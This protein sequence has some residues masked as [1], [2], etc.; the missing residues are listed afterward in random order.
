M[1]LFLQAVNTETTAANTIP[2][3]DGPAVMTIGRAEGNDF[4]LNHSSI[5]GEHA[6][7]EASGVNGVEL[8]DCNSSNG[9]FVNGV[10][11]GRKDLRPGDVVKFAYL[12]YRVVESEVP[13]AQESEA[14]PSLPEEHEVRERSETGGSDLLAEVESLRSQLT[15]SESGRSA[16]ETRLEEGRSEIQALR[17]SL[18]EQQSLLAREKLARQEEAAV[19]RSLESELEV[20]KGRNAE[21]DAG[22]REEHDAR[23]RSEA[24][25]RELQSEVESLRTR[26]ANSEE[27]TG[28]ANQQIEEAK[29]ENALLHARIDEV[30][31]MRGQVSEE[32]AAE[33]SLREQAESESA[34][35]LRE[36]QS[37]NEQLEKAREVRREREAEILERDRRIA[38]LEFEA[39][40]QGRT[41]AATE[42]RVR[43]LEG[44]CTQWQD[45][46]EALKQSLAETSSQLDGTQGHLATTETTLEDFQVRLRR[47]LDQ[48]RKDWAFWRIE[49]EPRGEGTP[50]T[51][52]A[53]FAEAESLRLAMRRELD[54]VEPI[55]EK[56]G[57]R[58]QVELEEQV[59]SLEKE[60][61]ELDTEAEEKR[62]EV[63]SLTDDVRGLREEVDVEVRRAQGLSRRGVQIEIP[64]RFEAMVIAKDRERQILLS[65]VN[66]LEFLERLTEGYRRSRKLREVVYE[67][68]ELAKRLIGILEENGVEEFTVEP[69]SELTLKQRKEVQILGKKGWGTRDYGEQPFQPGIVKKVIRTGYRA[70]QGEGSVLLRKVEVLIREVES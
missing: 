13:E 16:A 39:E 21:I 10:R 61:G 63:A 67:L 55:W 47:Y 57:N 43:S 19:I 60:I 14:G 2:V 56:F 45:A 52:E 65:L 40:R 54:E 64:E 28:I 53:F 1:P 66:Q 41:L 27:E 30:T 68:E 42:E 35:R 70:G 22:R 26:L 12:A 50:D 59:T 18:G 5:S 11:I 34:K 33:R 38:T 51:P 69:G 48:L 8:V 32:A 36:I 46:Y 44:D 24:K 17:A 15:E 31:A 9:T 3:P 20:L 37:L 23:E 25:V 7:I 6:R 49:T 62:R 4:L 29:Q 58:V